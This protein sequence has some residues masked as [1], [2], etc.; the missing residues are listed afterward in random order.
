MK[1]QIITKLL[2]RLLIIYTALSG[3]GKKSYT[4]KQKA[5]NMVNFYK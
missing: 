4:V 1:Y 3:K 5:H 2:I